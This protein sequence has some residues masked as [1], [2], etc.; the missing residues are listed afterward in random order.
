MAIFN[1]LFLS[2]PSRENIAIKKAALKVTDGVHNTVQ[3][4]I[5]GAFYLLS[6]KNIK[7]GILTIGNSDRKISENTFNRLRKRTQLEKGDILLSSVGTV[8]EIL[9]L[10][11]EP[12]NFEFQRSVAMIKP[13]QDIIS[14]VYM[15]EA[16]LSQKEKILN[17][18]HGAV[19]Q[20]LFISDIEEITIP[21][22]TQSELNLFDSVVVP[23]LSK[24]QNN[25]DEN[26]QLASIR[27]VLLPKLM[28][29][30]IDVSN[31]QI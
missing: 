29:G 18:A 3:D 21:L 22:P 30:E 14:S 28:S 12:V 6:C 11:K 7:G 19:Q 24:M 31:I 16:L 15:Y 27:D 2:N 10:Q 26:N 9:L 17:M 4:D 23:L 8:G 13:N 20:C 25:L 1:K 5:N